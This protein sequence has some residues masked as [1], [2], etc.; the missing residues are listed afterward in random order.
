MEVVNLSQILSDLN[1]YIAKL[2]TVK[3]M[4]QRKVKAQACQRIAL[5]LNNID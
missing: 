1:N 5:M 3:N 4:K 2:S